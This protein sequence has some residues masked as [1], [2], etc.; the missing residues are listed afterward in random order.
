ML[1][2]KLQIHI[3]RKTRQNWQCV[4]LPTQDRNHA[5]IG[6]SKIELVTRSNDSIRPKDISGL[7]FKYN[8]GHC[9]VDSI[10]QSLD[11]RLDYTKLNISILYIGHLVLN[12]TLSDNPAM[13]DYEDDYFYEGIEFSLMVPSGLTVCNY[14]LNLSC[15]RTKR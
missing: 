14:P 5:F 15:D 2:F 4:R 10:V 9:L 1:H 7:N 3:R 11:S 8:T 6:L 12:L 13:V